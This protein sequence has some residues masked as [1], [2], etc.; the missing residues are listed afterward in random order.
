V[1][2]GRRRLALAMKVVEQPVKGQPV[3][4]MVLPI[5]EIGD[6]ELAN[7]AGRGFTFG[8]F[9]RWLEQAILELSKSVHTILKFRFAE[10]AFTVEATKKILCGYGAFLV[11]GLPRRCD[12][13]A[14]AII[15]FRT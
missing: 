8:L 13:I 14:I 15:T 6:M 1:K 10:K 9:Q 11:V 5:A 3:G 4:I 7:L 12:A 2:S